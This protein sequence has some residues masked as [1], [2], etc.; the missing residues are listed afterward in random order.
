MFFN[1]YVSATRPKKKFK[2]PRLLTIPLMAV[3]AGLG[4]LP[5]TA[6]ARIGSAIIALIAQPQ[7]ASSAAP[8]LRSQF[9]PF[10]CPVRSVFDGAR[11]PQTPTPNPPTRT[12]PPRP[13][14]PSR[15]PSPRPPHTTTPGR[16]QTPLPLTVAV[17]STLAVLV[18]PRPTR[19]PG[20][21]LKLQDCAHP[22]HY[23]FTPTPHP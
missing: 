8:A 20:S 10:L 19:P 6:R 5:T 23:R 1:I 4:H 3:Q 21:F 14:S 11:P 18:D 17:G 22:P 7:T 16:S 12:A 9:G 2:S 15:T 13:I